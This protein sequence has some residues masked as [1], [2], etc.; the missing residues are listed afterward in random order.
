L[1]N[2]L[3]LSDDYA[4]VENIVAPM[5]KSIRNNPINSLFD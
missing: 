1:N 4:P 3:M 5:N 2:P